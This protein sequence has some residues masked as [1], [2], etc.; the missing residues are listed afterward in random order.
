MKKKLAFICSECGY[1]SPKWFGKCPNCG[2]LDS[3]MEILEQRGK[4]KGGSM[5]PVFYINSN[6]QFVKNNQRIPTGSLEFDQFLGG[7]FVKG[8]VVLL[9]GEPGIGKSTLALQLCDRLQ[10]SGI[11]T[12]YASGEESYEQICL[13][14]DRLHINSSIAVTPI[15]NVDDLLSITNEYDFVVVDSIQTFYTTEIPSPPGSVV[16]VK[17]VVNKLVSYA[18]EKKK[19]FMLIGHVTKSGEIAGPKTV[20]HMV[21]TVLYFEGERTSDNRILRVYKN[22]FGPAGELLIFEMH[23][24][25]LKL[26]SNR[27][28]IDDTTSFGNVVSCAVEGASPIVI[29]IQALVS[30]SKIPSPRRNSI[31]VDLSRVNSIIAVI[32]KYLKI[33]LDL[34]EIYVKILGGIRIYDPGIDLAIAGAILSS[35]LEKPFSSVA[36][37]GEVGLDARVRKPFS[38]KKRISALKKA[39]VSEIACPCEDIEDVVNVTHLKDL[40]RIMG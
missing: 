18:K 16:Q 26:A 14:S 3:A 35:F 6:N 22:R 8:Q 36:L 9:G 17:N 28:F 24:S 4:E 34:H 19:I 37:I 12:L 29:Q 13:R 1:T 40:I 30:R 2:A 21:D 33:P 39:K 27:C 20:E 38:I 5:P 23:D 11:K 7:G 10:K 15:Q 32:G 31:G 25:G